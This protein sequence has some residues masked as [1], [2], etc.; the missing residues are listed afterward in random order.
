MLIASVKYARYTLYIIRRRSRYVVSGK[1]Y[2][3]YRATSSGGVI[4]MGG[5]TPIYGKRNRGLAPAT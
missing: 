1:D 2:R 3:G 5:R 4:G